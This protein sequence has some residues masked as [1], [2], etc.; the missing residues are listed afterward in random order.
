ELAE[1]EGLLPGTRLLTLWGSGGV[2]KTRLALELGGR[3]LDLFADGVWL[4]NLAPLDAPAL[5][6]PSVM[7][8]LGIVSGVSGSNEA[9]P[10]G[11]LC[12][13]LQ[14][15]RL[16]LL[17]DN[18]E[19]VVEAVAGLAHAL[20][21]RCPQLSVLATSRELLAIPGERAWPVPPLSL[22]PEKETEPALVGR[23][24]AA[25]LF[26]ERAHAARAGFEL[27]EANV[28]AVVQICHQLD[29]NPLALEL[30]AAR[31]RMLGAAR[32]AQRLGDRFRVLTVGPRTGDRRHHTLRA[33][34]DW[35]WELLSGPER[36]LLACLSVFP[37]SFDLPAAESVAAAGG[38]SPPG[39]EVLDLLARLVDKSLVLAGEDKGEI[40]YR[41]LETV[42]QYAGEK[43]QAAG[44]ARLVRRRH[45]DHFLSSITQDERGSLYGGDAVLARVHRDWDNFR[46]ALEWSLAEADVDESIR[47]TAGIWMYWWWTAHPGGRAW[48]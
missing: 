2:G 17:L 33:M 46:A 19:H 8:A 7:S 22:P 36:E 10:T 40:R 39:F 23:C 21:A 24:D 18:C 47:L 1:L 38:E 37:G 20:L 5:V 30:A 48:L 4:V 45:R 34:M 16:M 12:E 27:S 14:S 31:V 15:R 6:A 13:Y 28:G 35:S 3:A 29:G 42:R 26:C 43:I 9:E 44:Q 32:L 11:Q 41:L 25:A